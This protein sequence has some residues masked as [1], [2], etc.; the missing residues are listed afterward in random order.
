MKVASVEKNSQG[1]YFERGKKF[2]KAKW[3]SVIDVYQTELN[4]AGNIS[5][6]HRCTMMPISWRRSTIELRIQK[7]SLGAVREEGTIKDV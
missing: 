6:K 5:S 1:G 7:M 2:S 4:S 3:A